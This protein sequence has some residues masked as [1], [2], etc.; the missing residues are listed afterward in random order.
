MKTIAFVSVRRGCLTD[1]RLA[2]LSSAY[3]EGKTLGGFCSMLPGDHPTTKA[4]LDLLSSFGLTPWRHPHRP[5]AS[6][7][8]TLE[9]RRTYEKGDWEPAECLEPRPKLLI[10][11]DSHRSMTGVLL[12]EPKVL[13]RKISIAQASWPAIVVSE[14]LKRQILDAGLKHV[15]FKAAA[16]MGNPKEGYGQ[17]WDRL[18]VEVARE[19]SMGEKI[20]ETQ[21]Q[22]AERLRAVGQERAR[23]TKITRFA[24]GLW[25][26]SSD[27]VL[28]RLSPRCQLQ[29]EKGEPVRDD[30]STGIFLREDLYQPP[31]L[32]YTRSSIRKVEPFDLAL[33]YEPLSGWYPTWEWYRHLVASKRF[34]EFCKARKLKMDWIPVRIDPD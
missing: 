19:Q 30:F 18:L 29:D 24:E 28:P 26:L 27:L 34:Y 22:K 16:I 31:E 7:E 5:I 1:E 8:Y 9:Y 14:E 23:N 20:V 10:D 6:T 33:T 13:Q 4:I 21:R 25:E 15:A 17:S 11:D 32:R 2:A 3:P 12:V